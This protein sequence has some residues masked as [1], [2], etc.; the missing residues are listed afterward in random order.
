MHAEGRQPAAG[1][2]CGMQFVCA[3]YAPASGRVFNTRAPGFLRLREPCATQPSKPTQPDPHARLTVLLAKPNAA[4]SYHP[5]CHEKCL[6]DIWHCIFFGNPGWSYTCLNSYNLNNNK[7]N[8]LDVGCTRQ[9]F[10]VDFKLI[11]VQI[12]ADLF[13]FA[14]TDGCHN[15]MCDSL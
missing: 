13:A 4:S 7:Q 14:A 3:T 12:A 2:A 1:G 10:Y 9:S 11:S 5:G 8:W 6:L 15:R